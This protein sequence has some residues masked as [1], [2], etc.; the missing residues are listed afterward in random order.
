[1]TG[2]V[3]VVIACFLEP[4]LVDRIASVDPERIR[5][6]HEPD[7]LPVPRF[8][9]DH[10]GTPRSLD[11]A[12]RERW[13]GLLG[14]AEVML[15][16]DWMEPERLPER[17]PRLRW[18]QG[19]SAGMGE[20]LERTGLD[21]TDLVVTTA[22]GLFGGPVAEFVVLGLLFFAKDVAR[23]QERQRLHRWERHAI[24]ELAGRR[25][26]V[27]GLGDLGSCIAVRCN[28]L[29]ME[30]WGARRVFRPDRPKLIRSS[31]SG[32]STI[33]RCSFSST[34]S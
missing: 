33:P 32:S 25:V 1:M 7:L 30:V 34:S 11:E 13:L 27:L 9:G 21:R 18:I 10:H 8:P 31:T 22:S 3:D 4:E 14:R 29:G 24:G 23:L 6:H 2:P 17:A 28:A 5:V 19:T 12:G 20:F 16:V 26:L 15:H